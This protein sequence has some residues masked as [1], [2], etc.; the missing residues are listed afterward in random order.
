MEVNILELIDFKR[1]ES[2][3]EGFN[4]TTGFVTAI[5][6][7]EGKVISKSGWRRAC[8]DFHRVNTDTA[9][10]CR[11]SDT[12]LAEKQQGDKKIH[13][14]KCL[15]G[16]TD[17]AVPI[18]IKGQH[19]A[20]LF[21]G[22][23]FFDEPDLD[24]F[25][26]Q[27]I[28]FGFDPEDYLSAIKDVPV[29]SEEQVNTA[30]DFLLNMTQ[31]ISDMAFQRMEQTELARIMTEREQRYRLLFESNPHPMWVYD[32]ET[33][34][35]LEVNEVAVRKYGYNRDE[36]L[37]LTLK[38]IRPEEDVVKLMENVKQIPDNLSF[39]GEW[40]HRNKNGEI[41]LVEIISHGLI[42]N[43][44]PA[45]LVLANDIT[46]RKTAEETMTEQLNELQRWHNLMLDRED[47]IMDLKKEVNELLENA[48]Q[49]PRY[50]TGEAAKL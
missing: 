32:L 48:S 40:R 9:V 34:Q 16:M 10:R 13:F 37:K 39:S 6:D 15:N 12:V 47:R 21:S 14:Y 42:F 41:F 46:R 2:L 45:R 3:L 23:L 49:P 27:A 22:Q 29:L 1:V 17:V 7:L 31:L 44:R 5:L 4:K 38:D 8:T 24:F 36:F 25:R 50:N 20:N 30:M 28:E 26:K 11:I 33:L 19:V 18:V 35:F 43:K